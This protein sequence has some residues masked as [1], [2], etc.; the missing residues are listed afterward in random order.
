[1]TNNL[2]SDS[3]VGGID[4]GRRKRNGKRDLVDPRTIS[5]NVRLNQDEFAYLDSMRKS[6]GMLKAEFLRAAAFG[7]LPD[8]PAAAQINRSAW[9]KLARTT[10]NLNQIAKHLNAAA[11]TGETPQYSVEEI[12]LELERF[13]DSLLGMV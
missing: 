7:Q 9:A 5:V 12:Q 10:A 13:R 8:V 1:M 2:I 11:L 4:L 3:G 6:F